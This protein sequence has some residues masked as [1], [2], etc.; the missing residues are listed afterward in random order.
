[1][2]LAYGQN[3][4]TTVAGLLAVLSNLRKKGYRK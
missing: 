1:M 2:N 4:T 3:I